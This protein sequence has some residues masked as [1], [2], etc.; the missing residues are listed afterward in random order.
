LD[1]APTVLIT[2]STDG[3]GRAAAVALARLGC[4]VLLHGRDAR[5]CEAA[6]AAVAAAGGPGLVEGLTADL[7]SLAAVCSL[8][9]EV[10]ARCDR[11]DILVNNAGVYMTERV[12]TGDALETTFQVNHLAPFLLTILLLPLLESSAPARVVNVASVA[13]QRADID[14]GNLQGERRWDAYGAYALSKLGN[15]LFTRE[16]AARLTGRGVTVNCL[17]P[18]VIDTKLLRRA[19][20]MRGGDVADAGERLASLALSPGLSWTTGAYFVDGRVTVPAAVSA[21]AAVRRRFW[22]V[23]EQLAG[24]THGLH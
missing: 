24:L 18:G 2:G 11:L 5:R 21:D 7:T 20:A 22:L 8:A 4:R 17:H 9:V 12:L 1:V 16:L 23:S 6:R 14:W 3:I 13:H 10:G 15:V 19:F